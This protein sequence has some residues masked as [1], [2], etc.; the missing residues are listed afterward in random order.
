MAELNM[1]KQYPRHARQRCKYHEEQTK[2]RP[3]QRNTHTVQKH[4]TKMRRID[5][6]RFVQQQRILQS[7]QTAYPPTHAPASSSRAVSAAAPGAPTAAP[8]TE[9]ARCPARAAGGRWPEWARARARDRAQR[10]QQRRMKKKMRTQ[11]KTRR[12]RAQTSRV[13]R[14]VTTQSR[15]SRRT[16]TQSVSPPSADGSD[17]ARATCQTLDGC[18]CDRQ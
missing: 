16:E 17:R 2:N 3:A 12:R 8:A 4:S 7:T 15:K 9:S 10:R 14:R 1:C 13:T 18:A 6:I 5:R 11:R